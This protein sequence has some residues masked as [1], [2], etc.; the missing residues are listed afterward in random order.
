MT[1]L[2][3]K[4]AIKLDHVEIV[5]S[6]TYPKGNT[7]NIIYINIYINLICNMNIKR[8]KLMSVAKRREGSIDL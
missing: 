7:L 1:D 4:H 5:R 2:T 6:K 8:N 3:P